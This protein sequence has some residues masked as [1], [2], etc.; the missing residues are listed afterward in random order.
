MKKKQKQHGVC[1][2]VQFKRVELHPRL[3]VVLGLYA[4][5][6]RCHNGPVENSLTVKLA[7]ALK[8]CEDQAHQTLC[9]TQAESEWKGELK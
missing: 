1:Q 6:L 3:Y 5:Y 7:S 2:V 4:Y 9:N 8:R